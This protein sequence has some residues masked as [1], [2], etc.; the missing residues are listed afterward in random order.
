[1]AA[2]ASYDQLQA[3][4]SLYAVQQRVKAAMLAAALTIYSEASP[5]ANHPARAAFA[6]K[7]LLNT[8]YDI[9]TATLA[10][11]AFQMATV[12]PVAAPDFAVTDTL[13]N[14]SIAS[15]WNAL[16]GA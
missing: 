15:M 14:N 4:G 6:T 10:V 9:V 13:L 7:V 16:A 5:P 12:D 3:I 2:P 8:G 11:L 1:M